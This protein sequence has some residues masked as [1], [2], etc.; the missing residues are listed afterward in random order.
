MALRIIRASGSDAYADPRMPAAASI[1]V[2]FLR[3]TSTPCAGWC[4]R[5]VSVHKGNAQLIAR[6][7]GD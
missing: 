7:A 4:R 1:T 3:H 2:P 6:G 5:T